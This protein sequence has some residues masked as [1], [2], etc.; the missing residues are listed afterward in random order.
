[1]TELKVG[2]LAQ[3]NEKTLN[4]LGNHLWVS[5]EKSKE[6]RWRAGS[7]TKRRKFAYTDALLV[8]ETGTY[9]SLVEGVTLKDCRYNERVVLFVYDSTFWTAYMTHLKEFAPE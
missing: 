7:A 2:S 6:G 5:V 4:N 3:F 1:M 8:V 9:Y